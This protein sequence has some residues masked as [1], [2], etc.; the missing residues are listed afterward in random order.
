MPDL[1]SRI[2]PAVVLTPLNDRPTV[3]GE[4]RASLFGGF[5]DETLIRSLVMLPVRKEESSYQITELFLLKGSDAFIPRTAFG[6]KLL[7][8]RNRAIASGMI[9]LSDDEILEEVKR[10]RGGLDKDAAYVY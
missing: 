6:E 10:R 2:S 9:L 5:W 3:T 1:L 7:S 4:E 8:L